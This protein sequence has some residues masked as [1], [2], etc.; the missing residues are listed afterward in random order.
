VEK[1]QIKQV[2]L[3]GVF[4][5][6]GILYSSPTAA[7]FLTFATLCAMLLIPGYILTIIAVVAALSVV[8]GGASVAMHNRDDR[9]RNYSTSSFIGRVNC[10]VTGKTALQKNYH[11]PLAKVRRYRKMKHIAQSTL[12]IAL[13]VVSAAI[14]APRIETALLVRFPA[15]SVE[16]LPAAALP[17]KMPAK[18]DWTTRQADD[19]NFS[20]VLGAVSY[21]ESNEG[22]YRPR[23]EVACVDNRSQLKFNTQEILATDKTALKIAIGSNEAIQTEWAVS[24]D[25]RTAVAPHAITTIK[26]IGANDKFAISYLPFG[27]DQSKTAVFNTSKSAEAISALRSACHW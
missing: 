24:D 9:R 25:Y 7:L 3:V 15:P 18:S 26:Q 22:L 12:A 8:C 5:P 23:L 10:K 16:P 6:L 1:S 20:A 27:A 2:L 19:G 13:A 17:S 4:G 11:N 14:A 21:Q